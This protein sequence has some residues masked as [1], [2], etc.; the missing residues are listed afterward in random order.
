MYIYI[1]IYK[2]YIISICVLLSPHCLCGDSCT[3]AHII[4]ILYITYNFLI[5]IYILYTY[6]YYIYYIYILS[7][8]LSSYLSFYIYI[9]IYIYIT[10][11]L[12]IYT[13]F[14]VNNHSVPL[15]LSSWNFPKNFKTTISQTTRL[16]L[17]SYRFEP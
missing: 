14:T 4:Y 9:Y 16:L 7:I 15:Q 13:N 12:H 17:F 1:Y 10:Y 11:N 6:I 5:I 2:I 3:W 8:Y